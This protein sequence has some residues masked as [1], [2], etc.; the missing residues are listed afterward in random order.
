[1]AGV[2]KAIII[3]RLGKDPEIRYTNSGAPVANFT[4]ATSESWTGKDGKKDERTE[5]HKVV[6]WGKL[7]E[8]CGE[9]LNKGRRVYVEG[10]IQTR[11]YDGKDGNK[12]YITEIV[13]QTV[14]FL[15]SPQQKKSDFTQDS[16]MSSTN[17]ESAPPPDDDIPF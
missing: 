15:D 5:W 13:A 16:G 11:S 7:G 12:K 4:V 3:G 6:A 9:Y 2:N 14:Q 10:R 17:A 8:L 1:M